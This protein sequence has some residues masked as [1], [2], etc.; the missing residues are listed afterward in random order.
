MLKL[1][2]CCDFLIE[3]YEHSHTGTHIKGRLL[4]IQTEK[5]KIMNTVLL[6]L[7]TLGKI[8]DIVQKR[9]GLDTVP[10]RRNVF[11]YQKVSGKID[12]VI[13]FFK[14]FLSL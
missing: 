8:S 12:K 9:D 11:I 3:F 4:E 6:L 10:N 2:T 14:F 7:H 5:F 1:F 13:L